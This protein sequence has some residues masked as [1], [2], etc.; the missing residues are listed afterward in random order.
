MS[1]HRIGN[2]LDFCNMFLFE[3]H[4]M[5]TK[6]SYFIFVNYWYIFAPL[7]DSLITD[8]DYL[9]TTGKDTNNCSINNNNLR[10]KI[11]NAS[12]TESSN[13]LAPH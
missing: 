13:I 5:L 2:L 10:S 7:H 11:E 8:Y 9:S 6:V 3:L 4:N 12:A 1:V